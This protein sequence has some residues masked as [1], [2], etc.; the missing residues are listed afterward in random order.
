MRALFAGAVEGIP[1][2]YRTPDW[3]EGNRYVRQQFSLWAGGKMGTDEMLEGV[4]AKMHRR[5]GR[6]MAP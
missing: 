4:A 1:V 3:A 6:E 2:L 5:L